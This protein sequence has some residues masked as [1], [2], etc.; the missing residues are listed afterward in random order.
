MSHRHGRTLECLLAAALIGVLSLPALAQVTD[1]G[2]LDLL[3]SLPEGE[4]AELLR[5][6]GLAPAGEQQVPTRD[7]STPVTVL[8]REQGEGELESPWATV[9]GE[10]EAATGFEPPPLELLPEEGEIIQ[11]AFEAFLAESRPLEVDS[12][13]RQFG[14]D[15]FAGAPT[16]FA[17]A[18][19]IPV[20]ADY[21]IGPGDEVHVQLYG[22][23]NLATD[24]VVDR[25]GNVLFPELGPVAVAGL[26]FREMKELI[27]REVDN[28]TIGSSVSVSMGRLRSIRVFVLGDVFRP[29]SYTVSGLSTLTN[30]LFASGGVRTIGSLR[31]VQLKRAGEVV[32]EMDL[33]D[34]LIRGDTSDDARLMPGDVIFIPTVGPLVGVA[35]EVLRP[36]IYEMN[37][38]MTARDLIA[39]AG[40]LKPTAFEGLVQLERIDDDRYVTYDLSA[41]EAGEWKLR[42]G[43]LLKVYPVAA[44]NELAVFLEGNVVRPGKRQFVDGMTLLDLIPSTEDLLPETFFTYGL[45]ER[46]SETTREPEYLA[47]NLREA[48]LDSAKSAGANVVLAPRDRVHVFHRAHFREV[49]RVSVRGEVRF[50]GMYEHKK[51]MRVLDLILAAGGL[52]REAWIGEAELFRTEPRRMYVDRVSIDLSGV[53]GDDPRHNVVLRDMDELAIHSLWEFR[54][55]DTVEVLGEVNAPG[56]YPLSRGMRVSDLVFAGG[57]LRESA[58][59]QEAE[60]TRYEV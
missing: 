6:Y 38:S 1:A 9:G 56:T 22:K 26:T 52:T 42:G 28:R 32:S 5:A 7:V 45:I 11:K 40:G 44:G 3:R 33:Y 47:F 14:Y 10:P 54:E 24:L 41:D 36:A 50:P 13:L 21:I 39:L 27:D 35:G 46:E 12:N 57:N 31:R 4:R 60:L 58:Y 34:L 20:S 23:T 2:V 48:L 37:G 8:P 59:K 15:L 19:D 18:T 30:A 55:E 16:T 53:L 49:P 51:D 17:P 43:D 25:D 29:G